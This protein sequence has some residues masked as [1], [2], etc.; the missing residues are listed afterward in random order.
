MFVG[1]SKEE[2]ALARE[3]SGFSL[4]DLW[5]RKAR[6]DAGWRI[7]SLEDQ[8]TGVPQR[9]IVKPG[10]KPIP[11]PATISSKSQSQGFDMG[12][13]PPMSDV[14]VLDLIDREPNPLKKA[15]MRDNFDRAR[16]KRAERLEL[17]RIPHKRR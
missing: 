10:E 13:E 12:A 8:R 3:E 15:R 16:L 7:R 1:R 6:S 4:D 5:K 9:E 11:V 14:E 17:A 2:A